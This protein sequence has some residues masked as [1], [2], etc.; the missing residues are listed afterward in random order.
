MAALARKTIEGQ[1]ADSGHQ[2]AATRPLDLVFLA[3]QTLGD[4][5]LEV[6]L[7]GM[8][9][10]QAE[11]TMFKIN[12][13]VGDGRR[14]LA[15]VVHKLKG[16]ARAIGATGVAAAAQ[17]YEDALDTHGAEAARKSLDHAVRD[18]RAAIAEL[19]G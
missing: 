19:L 10:R 18:A 8:F 6:E 11:K 2:G 13:M 15:D 7:L 3:R 4:R 17:A 16:S 12:Q 1:T 5:V 9:D 14:A